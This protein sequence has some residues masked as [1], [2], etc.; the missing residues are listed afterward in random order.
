MRVLVFGA[1][2]MIGSAMVRVLSKKKIG[3]FLEHCDQK[4]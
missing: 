4:V 2:G 1:S 3:R